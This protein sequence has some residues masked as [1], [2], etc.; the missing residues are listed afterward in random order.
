M[1]YVLCLVR[2]LNRRGLWVTYYGMYD[3]RLAYTNFYEVSRL[4]QLVGIQL[5]AFFS[6]L[7]CWRIGALYVFLGGGSLN[8]E[9]LSSQLELQ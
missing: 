8:L 9:P 2:K 4:A 1:Y 5:K 7:F 3:T 6:F